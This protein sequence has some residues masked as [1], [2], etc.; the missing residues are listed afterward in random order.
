M[1]SDIEATLSFSEGCADI[2]ARL[3]PTYIEAAK[4]SVEKKVNDMFSFIWAVMAIF[5]LEIIVGTLI[6]TCACLSHGNIS[7]NFYSFGEWCTQFG[8]VIKA[9]TL[10]N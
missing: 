1:K 3:N 6:L 5:F 10:F 7:S 4:Q 2:T 8:K 9:Y